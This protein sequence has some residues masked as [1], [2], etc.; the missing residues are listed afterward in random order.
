MH[1]DTWVKIFTAVLD[2]K[3]ELQTISFSRMLETRINEMSAHIDELSTRLDERTDVLGA[4]ID[5]LF[6]RL[7]ERT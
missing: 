4:R 2:E 1:E 7:D 6:T 5:E 3:L